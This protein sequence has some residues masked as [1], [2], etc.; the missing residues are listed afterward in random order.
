MGHNSMGCRL[1]PVTMN[2]LVSVASQVLKAILTPFCKENLLRPTVWSTW[3]RAFFRNKANLTGGEL[4]QPHTCMQGSQ[5]SGR[6][7]VRKAMAGIRVPARRVGDIIPA[8]SVSRSGPVKTWWALS[9]YG[10]GTAVFSPWL[11][12]SGQL[13][14]SK[15]FWVKVQEEV[16]VATLTFCAF[17]SLMFISPVI[18]GEVG[19]RRK[20][21]QTNGWSNSKRKLALIPESHLTWGFVNLG[22]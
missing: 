7:Q 13:L 8:F 16:R 5:L 1:V 11:S 2:Y 9:A 18:G 10:W 17:V 6:R 4:T 22:K 12:A 15:Q 3:K 19:R 14:Y 21:L 20:C